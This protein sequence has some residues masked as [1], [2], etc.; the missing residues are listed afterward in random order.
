MDIYPASSGTEKDKI[1]REVIKANNASVDKHKV[2]VLRPIRLSEK[3]CSRK[4]LT[5]IAG[6]VANC[7]GVFLNLK[8]GRSQPSLTILVDFDRQDVPTETKILATILGRYP[9][10]KPP[11]PVTGAPSHEAGRGWGETG[12]GSGR[13]RGRGRGQQTSKFFKAQTANI[14]SRKDGDVKFHSCPNPGG[15]IYNAGIYRGK[16]ND[17]NIRLLNHR[18]SFPENEAFATM[19]QA[20]A[21][22]RRYY[23]EITD[24]RQIVEMNRNA[25]MY[26]SNLNNPSALIRDLVG[27]YQTQRLHLKEVFDNENLEPAVRALREA[28]T[29]RRLKLN[30]PIESSFLFDGTTGPPPVPGQQQWRPSVS[31]PAPAPAPTPAPAQ[32]QQQ[33]PLKFVF[34][35]TPDRPASPVAATTADESVMGKS[36]HVQEGEEDDN[37]LMSGISRHT[38]NLSISQDVT[39]A[40]KKRRNVDGSAT[41]TTNNMFSFLVDI[42]MLEL[43]ISKIS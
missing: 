11:P 15:G 37:S 12:R 38:S 5:K 8:D 35:D 32:K 36:V 20:F 9:T 33:D 4:A 31:T 27:N 39:S 30:A 19:E 29:A 10:L 24:Y 41:V 23:P 7:R 26:S 17:D 22:F 6:A 28:T 43:R 40:G 13:G 2:V 18:V 42:S 25:D 3:A 1:L 34:P 16:W 14:A 21:H